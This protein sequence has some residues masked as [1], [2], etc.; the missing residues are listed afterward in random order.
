MADAESKREPGTMI[1]GYAGKLRALYGHGGQPITMW[2]GPLHCD[3]CHAADPL[4]CG[5][6]CAEPEPFTAAPLRW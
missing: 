2:D 6:H 5:Q 3:C 4:E 1:A